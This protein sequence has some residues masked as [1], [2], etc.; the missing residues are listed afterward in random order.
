MSSESRNGLQAAVAAIAAVTA[1]RIAILVWSPL[2][3]YPDE[4]QY[5]WWAQSPAIGYVSKPPLIAWLIWAT[6]FVFGHAEWAIRLSMPLLHAGAA[7][8]TFALAR[9]AFPQNPRIALWSALAYLTLPGVTYSAM[10]ASTDAPLL[11]FWTLALYAFLRALRQHEWRWALLC[12]AAIGLGAL[13]KYAMV[14]FPLCMIVAAAWRGEARAFVFG[15]RGLA[16]ALVA[17]FI[18]LPNMLWN[19]QHGFATV[20][21]VE[22]NADWQRARFGLARAALF[23][24]GQAG[25]FG[26]LLAAAWIVALWRRLRQGADAAGAVLGVFSALPLVLVTAQ[27]FIAGANANWAAT[28]YVPG[29]PLAVAELARF[30]RRWPAAATA[31]IH[32]AAIALLSLFLLWPQLAD[33]LGA[34]NMFKRA[35]GWRVL[36]ARVS[37]IATRQDFAFIATSNRSIMAELLYYGDAMRPHLRMWD[38]APTVR[39]QFQLSMRLAPSSTR[40]LLVLPRGGEHRV[41]A[42]FESARLIATVTTAAGARHSRTVELFDARSYRGPRAHG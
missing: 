20:V 14:Y 18:V 25:V 7:L 32:G 9:E 34:G 16:A 11:F 6:T 41:P 10:I 29:V 27:A 15:R 23:L 33:S 42:D 35:E 21:Q 22:A 19:A 3:L 30:G 38:A 5:W 37:Q 31:A 28:A 36:A 24:L 8:L 26:P 17:G 13:A 12:G 39:N 2:E 4:A 40:V 1:F